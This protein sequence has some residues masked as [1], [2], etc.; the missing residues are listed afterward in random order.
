L[1]SIHSMQINDTRLGYSRGIDLG[2][3]IL[4]DLLEPYPDLAAEG[5]SLLHNYG[6][7]QISELSE[8][9]PGDENAGVMG[10]AE[11]AMRDPAFFKWHKFT[12]DFFLEYKGLLGPYSHSD[13]SYPGVEVV[14]LSVTSGGRYNRLRTFTEFT[15]LELDENMLSTMNGTILRYERLNHDPYVI[16]IRLH[17]AVAGGAVGRIFLIPTQTVRD[18]DMISTVVEM[19]KFYIDLH[20]G[21]NDITRHAIDSPLFTRGPPSLRNLQ[22]RLLRG[23]SET[24]FNWANCGWPTEL[25]VPKGN[26]KGQQF[27]LV[28]IV[29]KLLPTDR[30][31][32]HEWNKFSRTAWSWCGMRQGE[33][34]MPDSRPMGFP[35]DRPTTLGKIMRGRYNMLAVPVHIHHTG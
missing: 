16:N 15:T 12:D 5:A 34:S 27:E 8:K 19:D 33:G 23:I 31:G 11:T 22:G 13:L 29:S 20:H 9:L 1:R 25:A 26:A 24:D 35:F 18:P 28:L 30:A 4:G 14:S 10:F 3:S 21:V 17:S 2:I 7:V 6:H 32:M